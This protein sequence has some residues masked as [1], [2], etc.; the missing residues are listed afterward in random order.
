MS[1]SLIAVL[2]AAGLA[3]FAQPAHA[4]IAEVA[5]SISAAA[6][7]DDTQ[8]EQA[9]QKA[10]R[11][12]LEQAIAFTPSMVELRDVKRLGDRVYLLFLVAD[13]D[14]EQALKAFVDSQTSPA[15]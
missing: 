8:L 10:F 15:D 3:A 5:T 6:L 12:V 4:F 1:K 13:A 9:I 14:G 7:A 11:D 2:I